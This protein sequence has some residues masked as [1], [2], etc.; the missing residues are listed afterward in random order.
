MVY[1]A[2]HHMPQILAGLMKDLIMPS[3]YEVATFKLERKVDFGPFTHTVDDALPLRKAALSIFA[4]CV[5]NLPASLDIG[6]FMP[7][8]AKALGD[9]EDVQLQAYQIV[10]SMCVRQPTYLV[11]AVEGFVD[12]LEKTINKKAGQK[13]GTEL[14][15][16]NDWIKG[17]LRAMLALSRLEGA[18]NCRKFADLCE[19]TR[20]NSKFR[21]IMESLEEER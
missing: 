21:T 7:I 20:M 18:M 11:A 14:E 13:T 8:L 15:R 12:P 2:V 16:L 4:T 6:A 3:L 10:C 5:E 9:V 1:S 19:R 17:A